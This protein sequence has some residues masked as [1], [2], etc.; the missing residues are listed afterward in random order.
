MK[1]FKLLSSVVL[2]FASFL[3]SCT[4][5][6]HNS[7]VTPGNGTITDLG[8]TFETTPSWFDEFDV[9][10]CP[11]SLKWRN[12]IGVGAD[13]GWGNAELQYYTDACT[14][15]KVN[16][17]NL[18]IEARKEVFP[19]GGR[20]YTSSRMKSNFS[21]K[22]GRFEARLKVPRGNGTWSAFWM[23]PSNPSDVWPISGELDVMEHV[24]NTP[25]KIFQTIHC[26][27]HN[28]YDR[29][30]L[31]GDTMVANAFDDYHVYRVDW[32]PYSVT[33]F[34]DNVKV[35]SY[36]NANSGIN[37]WPYNAS[38]F[39]ILNVAI[40]GN[41]GGAVDDSIFPAKMI[42]DYVRVYKMIEKK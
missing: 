6:E 41:W 3:Y 18:V 4:P 30:Q 10:G 35:F 24:G 8:W 22:Y 16:D 29:T 17:G 38:F 42:V 19:G 33:Y 13:G 31:G 40:G 2:V 28:G 20:Q 11:S 37:Q 14:N 25:N 15:A 12:D 36:T 5:S 23:L 21:Q 26:K 34:T 7:T 9:N 39:M 27:L 1:K 32:T